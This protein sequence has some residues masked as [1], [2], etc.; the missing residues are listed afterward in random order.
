MP[1]MR[2]LPVLC[3]T[4]C[5]LTVAAR[6]HA[7]T[8][9]DGTLAEVLSKA[10]SSHRWVVVDIFATWCGP[11]HEMDEK[12]YARPEVT[13][14][15]DGFVALR[16]DGEKDEGK[17]LVERYHTVG[18]PTLLVLDENGA[19]IDRLMGFVDAKALVTT[20]ENFRRGVGTLH[21][22][23]ERLRANASDENLRAEVATHHAMRGDLAALTELR[24][25][26][27]ADPDN[28]AK[29]ASTALLVLGKYYH[30]RGRKEPEKARDA[31]DEL[32]R[33]FP[34]SSEAEEA[35]YQIAIALLELNQAPAARVELDRWIAAAPKDSERYNA[36]AWFCFKNRAF[37]PRGIEVAHRG[38]ELDPK[39]HALWDTLAELYAASGKRS[40]AEAAAQKALALR[41]GDPYYLTQLKRFG[42][43]ATEKNP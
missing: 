13:R 27:N 39:A 29:R 9:A 33:R 26:I 17:T 15:L 3:T 28:K 2:L 20:L 25:V 8:W 38:L 23:E 41:P 42:P 10:K 24:Q 19:E 5:M 40:D 35:P 21:A 11:C 4:L 31:L 18:F 6:A 1:P 37:L 7:V 32:R 16:R 22:L 36:Y 30:L 12:V 43:P 14:V 34:T